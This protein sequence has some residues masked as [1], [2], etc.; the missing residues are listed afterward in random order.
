MPNLNCVCYLSLSVIF[1][2]KSPQRKL[3]EKWSGVGVNQKRFSPE[4]KWMQAPLTAPESGRSR[5]FRHLLG[6]L[7]RNKQR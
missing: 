5:L 1:P 3:L 6:A 4:S 2:G 7:I